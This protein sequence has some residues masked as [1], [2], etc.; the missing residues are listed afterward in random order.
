MKYLNVELYK[1]NNE[2]GK[3]MRGLRHVTYCYNFCT[4]YSIECQNLQTS[5]LVHRYAIGLILL[6]RD[7]EKPQI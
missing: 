5:N 2:V 7:I 4:S 3:R 1:P 6:H